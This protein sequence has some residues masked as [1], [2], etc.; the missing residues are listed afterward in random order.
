MKQLFFI[1]T[2]FIATVSFGQSTAKEEVDLLQ[3]LYGMGKKEIVA[4]F[5]KL[6][7]A[8]KDAFWSIY[9]A[10]EVD[11]KVLGQRRINL[12][13]TYAEFYSSLND[14]A[15]DILI[16]EMNDIT[17]TND[18]LIAKY[19]KKLKKPAGVKAAAQ[20]VQIESYLLSD[21]RAKILEEIPFIGQ[22][23]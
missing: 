15:T 9:D 5:I 1:A 4:N 12:L 11:R 19:Y 2:M 21:M 17:I 13:A 14:E 22:L 8:Q 6:E 10:Y 23:D 3:S 7:G 18:K 20:F 16:K